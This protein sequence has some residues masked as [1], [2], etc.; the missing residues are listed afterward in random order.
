MFHKT[1]IP[2]VGEFTE[3][4]ELAVLMTLATNLEIA[5][6]ALN[7]AYPDLDFDYTQRSSHSEQ[8]AFLSAWGAQLRALQIILEEYLES[9]Q[10][11]RYLKAP[12]GGGGLP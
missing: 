8:D 4:P 2:P 12:S 9:L 11:I 6:F 7:A 10:R 1:L 3:Y 5:Q